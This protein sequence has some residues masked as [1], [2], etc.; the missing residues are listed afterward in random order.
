ME[1][2]LRKK[3]ISFLLVIFLIANVSNLLMSP[4]IAN[5]RA[6]DIVRL[7]ACGMLIVALIMSL[8]MPFK[9]NKE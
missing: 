7:I 5:I 4:T 9:N 8:V 3:R 1:N 2:K 6:V